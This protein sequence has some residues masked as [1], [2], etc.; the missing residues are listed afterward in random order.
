MKVLLDSMMSQLGLSK[1][2][3]AKKAQSFLNDYMKAILAEQKKL[4]PETIN[5]FFSMKKNP[6]LK[7]CPSIWAYRYVKGGE[8]FPIKTIDLYEDIITEMLSDNPTVKMMM[9]FA[10]FDLSTEIQKVYELINTHLENKQ[11]D[12]EGAHPYIIG[13]P[14]KE[15]SN[16][17]LYKTTDKE[18]ILRGE[19]IE[20]INFTDI[21]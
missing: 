5:A 15:T 14:A 11:I 1:E 2:E 4:Y 3:L 18:N 12:F 21:F 8:Y 19:K 13:L 6:N 17:Y 16:L 9:K 7:A 20:Q 10:S